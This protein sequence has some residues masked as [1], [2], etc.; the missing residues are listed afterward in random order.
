MLCAPTLRVLTFVAV[1]PGIMA[2]GRI[3]QVK[4]QR[5]QRIILKGKVKNAFERYNN[6][7]SQSVTCCTLSNISNTTKKSFIEIS[8]HRE[9]S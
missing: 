5:D 8:K 6:A 2:M 3:V 9:E 7:V 1:Y 4:L